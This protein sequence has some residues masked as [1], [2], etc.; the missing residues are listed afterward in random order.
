MK[1]IRQIGCAV[2]AGILLCGMLAVAA[3]Q[4][5]TPDEQQAT[6]P[7]LVLQPNNMDQTYTMK[8]ADQMQLLVSDTAS[9]ENGNAGSGTEQGSGSGKQTDEESNW[10]IEEGDTDVITLRDDGLVTAVGEGTV[11]VAKKVPQG[12]VSCKITVSGYAVTDIQLT[13]ENSMKVG[14][15][16]TIRAEILPEQAETQLTWHSDNENVLTVSDD[17][18]VTA[19]STGRAE[20]TAEAENG[21]T[22]SVSITVSG[23]ILNSISIDPSSISMNIGD[24]KAVS[25]Q[26]DPANA[27]PGEIKWKSSDTSIA[28]Y[29]D[30]KIYASAPGTATITAATA[31]GKTASCTVKVTGSL[32]INPETMTLKAGATRTIQATVTPKGIAVTWSSSNAA[33]A[34]VDQTG[35]VT[36][37]KKGTAVITAKAGSLSVTCKVTVQASATPSGGNG[38]KITIPSKTPGNSTTIQ[39]YYNFT[40]A[41]GT[42]GILYIP[43]SVVSMKSLYTMPQHI[44]SA[45]YLTIDSDLGT[46]TETIADTLSGNGIPATFFVPIDDLYAADDVLRHIA[47][48]GNSIG[49]LLTADQ[50]N[51]GNIVELLDNANDQLSV[52]TGTPTH[53]VRIAG[54]SSGNITAE[55]AAV[56][57]NAGYRLWDWNSAARETVLTADSAYNAVCNAMNTTNSVTIRFG[58]SAKTTAVLQQLLPYMKYCG[59]PA[60]AISAGDIPVCNT[61]Q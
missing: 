26:T 1:K 21:M 51:A 7:E 25:I 19:V 47:G 28:Y 61:A 31:D 35:K 48:S 54:G 14:E 13:A 37:V 45:A 33:V 29:K 8:V 11:V 59:I 23:Y 50:A 15:T 43:G 38:N 18:T 20:I 10:I 3:P 24:S 17:G 16:Q 9:E 55:N 46:D 40:A 41:N 32:S 30:G 53:L 27:E 57:T 56:L 6:I 2:L 60:K 22:A 12:I 34:K 44:P 4:V 58:S 49:F 42:G 36:A 39:R 5:A 52:I